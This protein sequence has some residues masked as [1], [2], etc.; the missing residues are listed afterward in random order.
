MKKIR[1]TA[2]LL[3]L[4][5]L[6]GML[7]GCGDSS[8]G[9]RRRSK[10]SATSTDSGT[11]TGSDGKEN[12]NE[13]ENNNVDENESDKTTEYKLTAISP[14]SDDRAWV[15]F[16]DDDRNLYLGL[17]DTEGK[18]LYKKE[19]SG[20]NYSAGLGSRDGFSGVVVDGENLINKDGEVVA[21]TES[22]DFDSILAYGDGYA[23]VYKEVA[24]ISHYEK[25]LGVLD[26]N[27][28]WKQPLT[29]IGDK[30]KL[31]D[32]Y[33]AGCGVFENSSGSFLYNANTGKSYTFESSYDA[34]GTKLTFV[35]NV[36]YYTKRGV[37]MRITTDFEIET[38][39][40]GTDTTKGNF[41]ISYSDDYMTITDIRTG[42]E[43]VLEE[44]AAEQID[45]SRTFF[46]GDYCVVSINGKDGKHYFTVIDK[47]ADVLFDPIVGSPKSLIEERVIY[48]TST[49]NTTYSQIIDINGNILVE[50]LPYTEIGEFS[51]GL[52]EVHM[53][54]MVDE[55]YSEDRFFYINSAGETVIDSVHE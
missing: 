47:N 39:P 25:L 37:V 54:V 8:S 29:G 53:V 28:E 16:H 14:F 4:T 20:V 12:D 23:L 11:P 42:K 7:A 49:D 5:M 22:G 31:D 36:A 15:T 17:I 27:G 26:A 40:S 44:Y 21:T 30:Q 38:A 45:R 24:D 34:P 33:Y 1:L 55:W 50:K 46:S 13:G 41:R 18:I 51:C 32:M 10:D 35:D 48:T 19:S 2:L 52:A 43:A 9:S 6:V 3:V